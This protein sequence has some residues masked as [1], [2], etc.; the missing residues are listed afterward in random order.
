MK[1]SPRRNRLSDPPA[2]QQEHFSAILMPFCLQIF[3]RRNLIVVL[4]CIAVVHKCCQL[5]IVHCRT[6]TVCA[7]LLFQLSPK[8]F[9]GCSLSKVRQ[10]STCFKLF[11]ATTAGGGVLFQLSPKLF[12]DI[13]HAPT[14]RFFDRIQKHFAR[15]CQELAKM[16]EISKCLPT[17][18]FVA[19]YK[20]G[21]GV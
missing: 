4:Y 15:T 14:A 6:V 20:K 8:L 10:W 21:R 3:H 17:P 9:R 13:L 18:L 7:G 19:G 1:E 12:R 2:F 11:Q 16:S 5:F